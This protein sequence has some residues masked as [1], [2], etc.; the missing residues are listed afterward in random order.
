MLYLNNGT[1]LGKKCAISDSNMFAIY[2]SLEICKQDNPTYGT[3][4]LLENGLIDYEGTTTNAKELNK[5]WYLK[6]EVKQDIIKETSVCFIDEG[7]EFCM[8]GG[9]G[10][11][12][13]ETNAEIIREFM[14]NNS[15]CTG[16]NDNPSEEM[17]CYGSYGMFLKAN[18]NGRVAANLVG[19]LT[20]LIEAN[21]VSSCGIS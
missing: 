21:G 19:G 16:R 20:C 9:D 12:A 17:S 14:R 7:E 4:T 10:G 15:Y 11:K 2:P 8:K 18:S 6:H 13:Y 1:D 3:C 5:N